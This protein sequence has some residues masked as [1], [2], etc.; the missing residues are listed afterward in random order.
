MKK[1]KVV[2]TLLFIILSL[3]LIA[4]FCAGCDF[5][6]YVEREENQVASEEV[7][8]LQEEYVNKLYTV[9][10][11]IKYR[12][13][14]Q[15]LYEY[16]VQDAVNELYECYSETELKQV[17]E[18]HLIVIGKIKTDKEYSDE[19]EANAINAYRVAVLGQAE[20]SYD[21]Q[22]Y[23]DDQIKY[24]DDVFSAFSGELFETDDR[25]V[26][27][28]L[29]QEFYF[30]V[31]KEDEIL[32]LINYTDIS[33]YE[34]SQQKILADALD[35]C[36]ED[37]RS[38]D[39]QELID[40]SKEVYKFEVYKR[41]TVKRLTE[42]VDLHLYRNEQAA[43]IKKILTEH[44]KLAEE[45]ESNIEADNVFREY[46]I[47]VFDIPTEGMLYSEELS[48]LK[49]ELSGS[50]S[51]TYK[52]S[53]YRENEGQ[54]IQ[55][56]LTSF[57]DLLKTLK[58]KEDVLSQYVII[59]S[60]LDSVKTAKVLDEEDRT[61]LIEELYIQI[62]NEIKKNIDEADQDEFLVQAELTYAAMKDRVSLEGIRQEYR[63]FAQE[64]AFAHGAALE[65]LKE[66]LSEYKN[67]IFYREKEQN[68]VNALKEEYLVKFID[69]LDMEGAKALL[70]E[71][72][73]EIDKI[74]T[75]DDLW[76]DS[77]IK[78]RA[79]LRELYGDA[80]LEEP[81][82]LVEANDYYELADI[83]DYY[84]FY[85][86]NSSEFICDTFRVKLNF[87]H[88]DAW[89]ELVN[90]YWY[91]ELI[92]TAVGMTN[93]IENNSDY[94]VFQLIPYNF[95]SISN[96]RPTLNRLKSAVEFDSD[97]SQM[98]VR[99]DDFDDFA[100]YN[101]G[102]RINVWNSQQL[103]YALEHE[104]VPICAP[105]SP[106]E[107]VMNRAKEILREIIMEGMSDEEKIFQIY[108]WFGEN[109]QY[110]WNY[111]KY[112]SSSDKNKLPDE[113]ICKLNSL[114]IE[115]A[116]CDQLGVC[117]SYAK[118]NLLL[119]RLEGI[120]VFYVY[121]SG[122]LDNIRF[123]IPGHAFNYI[124]L[125]NNWY[126]GDALRSFYQTNNGEGIS[127]SYLLVSAKNNYKNFLGL[128][129]RVN[130]ELW[131]IIEKESYVSMEVYSYLSILDYPVYFDSESFEIFINEIT[132]S[133][134]ESFSIFCDRECFNEII[135]I[136]S[137]V[138]KCNFY[139]INANEYIE[140]FCS[141]LT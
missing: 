108:T 92:R 87:D 64:I 5:V 138:N 100:Y 7:R 78:F 76:N 35:D 31:H 46:Q 43:E 42:Y 106:A 15:K 86:L 89:T 60:R 70:Q 17:Y 72:K 18:K 102:R 105:D 134:I 82:S 103:W 25:E 51:D 29:L 132:L 120:S 73:N 52:L 67:T 135:D 137:K 94:L 90:V 27:N 77:V 48:E 41:D 133:D 99:S 113:N 93:Y 131:E 53:F 16:A 141:C 38:F 9:T 85:Q 79:D 20:E 6:Q 97:K 83:I 14:E 129:L 34:E 71:A 128:S 58:K 121:G 123:D 8:Q 124:K 49:T 13:N 96:E 98:T 101:Y 95:A 55:G 44:L 112:E 75:N 33:S 130:G 19:E 11:E 39:N 107:L 36:I 109:C 2:S 57:Q 139:H 22:K 118:A 140:V 111:V 110:D 32:S 136:L 88:N 80:I 40:G 4:C 24:F 126:I 61:N 68:E 1:Y 117:Y 116:I 69:D 115:G 125:N 56:I 81:R 122:I 23:T 74:K 127:Y 3:S 66:E 62:Q 91:C 65:I 47:A 28:G 37:I 45:A 119:L 59:K 114:H 12:E 21:K 63:A 50:L 26:M 84:A 54:V 10:S 104:Y 30:D